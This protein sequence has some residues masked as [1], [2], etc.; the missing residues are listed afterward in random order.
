VLM[1]VW[2]ASEV[3]GLRLPRN[4]SASDGNVGSIEKLCRQS[5]SDYRA[6]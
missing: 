2:S 4:R 6:G 5:E 3:Q 1:T